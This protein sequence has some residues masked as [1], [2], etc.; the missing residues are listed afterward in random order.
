LVVFAFTVD[1]FNA[2]GAIDTRSR[3]GIER[4]WMGEIWAISLKNKNKKLTSLFLSCQI[5]IFALT[6]V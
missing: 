6:P 1:I 2:I 3:K 5:F 4:H